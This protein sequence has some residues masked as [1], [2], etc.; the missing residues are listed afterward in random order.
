M[1]KK[2][3]SRIFQKNDSPPR[4]GVRRP[5]IPGG[6]PMRSRQARREKDARHRRWDEVEGQGEPSE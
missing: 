1:A 3:K 5:P 4:P 2:Q 6:F